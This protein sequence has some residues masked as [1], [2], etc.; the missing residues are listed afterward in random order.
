MQFFFPSFDLVGV[1]IL[2]LLFIFLFFIE[3]KYQLRRRKVPRIKRA[4]RNI[5]LASIALIFLRWLLIPVM[6]W[7]AS[8]IQTR[9]I[10]LLNWLSLHSWIEFIIGFLLLDYGNYLWH[11]INHKIPF[12]WRFHNVH[13]IDLDLDVTTAIRFHFGEI[14][15]SVFSRGAIILILGVSP[16]LVLIY[17]VFFEAATNFHHSNLRIPDRW[18]R[19]ITKVI[20]SPRMHGIHHSIVKRET[21]SNYSVI[22]NLWDRIH[23][24]LRLNIPQDEINIGVPSYRDLSEQKVHH[25]LIMPFRKQRPWKLPDGTVPEREENLK[26]EIGNLKSEI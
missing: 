21:D 24:T 25:L 18:E 2:F 7:L 10:G 12:L 14:I 17:E 8:W 13:H 1:P 16:V 20:V 23:R 11:L 15:L 19:R 9:N 5:G 3:S 6:V 4:L 26:S 22:F